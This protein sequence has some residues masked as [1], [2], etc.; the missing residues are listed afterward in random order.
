MKKIQINRNSWHYRFLE[1]ATQGE[2]AY[3]LCGYTRQLIGYSMAAATLLFFLLLLTFAMGDLIGWIAAMIVM[4]SWVP[5]QTPAAVLSVLILASAVVAAT[6]GISQLVKRD[7]ETTQLL[8]GA[9]ESFH[10]KVC[11]RIEVK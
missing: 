7:A 6:Y 1:T 11:F 4:Q 8:R 10:D 3:D 5:P 9:Y 2:V